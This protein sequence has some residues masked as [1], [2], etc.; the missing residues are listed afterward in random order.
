MSVVTKALLRGRID[1]MQI[2]NDVASLY[3]A[4]R[5]EMCIKFTSFP[6]Y[7]YVDFY[8]KYP[9]NWREINHIQKAAWRTNN[10]RRMSV[11]H[12]LEDYND[13]TEG[14]HYTQVSLGC[15]DDS[16][17][18]VEALLGKYGGFIMRDD[19]S[20]DWEIFESK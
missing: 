19:C 3:G 10:R 18:I 20:C 2:A 11:F 12:D 8:H 15:Y 1:I 14:D 6:D 9:D 4:D 13:I 17:K 7:H 5:S 16:V